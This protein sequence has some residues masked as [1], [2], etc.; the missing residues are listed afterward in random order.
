MTKNYLRKLSKKDK[1]KWK[2][3]EWNMKNDVLTFHQTWHIQDELSEG[4][5]F[6]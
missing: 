2:W 3:F 4:T 6:E 5:S 1:E